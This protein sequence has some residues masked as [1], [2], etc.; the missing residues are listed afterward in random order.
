MLQTMRWFGP[1]DPVSLTQIRQA[2]ATGV[3]TALHEIPVGEAWPQAA[4]QERRAMIED[5]GLTW[6]VVESIPVDEVIKTGATGWQALVDNY[7]ASLRAVANAG[8]SVVCYNFMPV[9][10]WTRTDLAWRLPSGALTLRFDATDFAV[11]DIHI[12]RRPGAADD[13]SPAT[14]TAAAASFA[15]KDKAAR[16]SLEKNI[17]AGL[18]G[19][20]VSYDR[21]GFMKRLAAYRGVSAAKLRQNLVRFLQAIVPVAAQAKLRMALHPDDPPWPLFGLPRVVSTAADIRAVLNAV[22]DPANGLTLCV[23][24]LNARPDND[25]GAMLKEF[26]QRINFL[27]LRSVTREADGSFFEDDHL[28]GDTGM[29]NVLEIMAAEQRRRLAQDK[30]GFAPHIPLRPDHG[31]LL[32]G[33]MHRPGHDPNPG[34]SLLG[35]LK[36]LAEIRGALYAIEK[37]AL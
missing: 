32:A 5:A 21:D 19:T 36:G 11:Y 15:A 10:D 8:V 24:S 16:Q 6:P 1:D 2:G 33:E 37:L 30:S 14:V 9:V 26:A 23:G 28:A 20:D 34:Y 22:D 27:H 25:I 13:Y 12:L 7:Q 35:R 31:H 29:L 17:I 18:P 4:V 3:V